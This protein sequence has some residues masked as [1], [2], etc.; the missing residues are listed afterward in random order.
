MPQVARSA[1]RDIRA[2]VC[3][4][5]YVMHGPSVIPLSV[6]KYRLIEA[7]WEPYNQARMGIDQ[8]IVAAANH[9]VLLYPWLAS[10]VA[11]VA[12]KGIWILPLAL[13]I[14]WIWPG[15]NFWE[16]SSAIFSGAISVLL[17]GL[18]SLAIGAVVNRPRP[19]TALPIRPLF[20]H[21]L[22]SSF[23]SDHTLLGMAFVLPLS[24][25]FPRAGWLL[26]CWALTVGLARMVAGV[27]YPSDI[28]F[29]AI[30]ALLPAILGMATAKAIIPKLPDRLARLARLIPPLPPEASGT[31]VSNPCQR[32]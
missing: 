4:K 2:E 25:R 8:R 16:R 13:L 7:L 11:L 21:P 12:E 15:V 3:A 20:P 24:M 14:V 31:K 22:D 17:A 19:F 23:P 1:F 30:L 26:S 9:F 29:S 6:H 27:H 10:A 18:L 5:R 28:I 32:P